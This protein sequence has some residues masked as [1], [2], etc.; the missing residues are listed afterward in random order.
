[1]DLAV[2]ADSDLLVTVLDHLAD[3]DRLEDFG[4]IS[5]Q[6]LTSCQT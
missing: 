6:F 4:T 5:N 3:S 1:M 2:A